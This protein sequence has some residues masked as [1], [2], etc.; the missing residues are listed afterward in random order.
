MFIAA[1][2]V[3]DGSS[4]ASLPTREYLEFYK[5]LNKFISSLGTAMSFVC[6]DLDTK[7][8]GVEELLELKPDHYKDIATM[9]RFEVDNDVANRTKKNTSS[10]CRQVLRL[11]RWWYILA[12]MDIGGWCA[13]LDVMIDWW[14]FTDVC[15]H[16]NS[17][18]LRTRT[19]GCVSM[20]H[21]LFAHWTEHWIF[22]IS[23]C[24]D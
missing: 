6:K 22:S 13:T 21:V 14:N 19:F 18:G 20:K 7:I 2:N 17:I 10:G 15:T 11:H 16:F 12:T 24:W 3:K 1:V 4:D 5:V 9:V 23:W 8:A